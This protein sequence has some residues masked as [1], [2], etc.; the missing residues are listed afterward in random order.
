MRHWVR[1]LDSDPVAGFWFPIS[2]GRFYPDFVCGLMDG[3]LFV[4]EY[5][6][7]HLRSV[8][9]EIEKAQVGRLWAERSA[10]RCR[11]AMLSISR[12]PV[13]DPTE[14]NEEPNFERVGLY[15]SLSQ[16]EREQPQRLSRG[17]PPEIDERRFGFTG[18]EFSGVPRR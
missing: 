1:D 16:G 7:E 18:S 5:K 15:R 8:S 11:F 14:F 3:R 13:F 12:L 2:S 9:K 6:G 10:G 4:T 17:N